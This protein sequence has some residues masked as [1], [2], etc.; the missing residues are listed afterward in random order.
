M[1]I[2]K[3]NAI[4]STNEHLKHL[5][6]QQVVSN[7]TVVW[8]KNQTL[9]KGQMGSS[10]EVEEGKNLTFSVLVKDLIVDVHQLFTLNIVVSLAVFSALEQI[11]IPKLAIKWPNDIL[12]GNSKI[13]GILIENSFKSNGEVYSVVGI[14]LNVNQLSFDNI[15]NASSLAK[16]TGKEYDLE[17][18]LNNILQFLQYYLAQMRTDSPSIWKM[19][20]QKLFKIGVPAPFEKP[21]GE[22]F[23]AII[24][25]V[26]PDGRLELLLENDELVYFDVKE[27]KLLY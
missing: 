8:A 26:I 16:I 27:V 12:S 22:K 15:P 10:W 9:G 17:V 21:N 20:H 25:K 19:Y 23:M 4:S 3:L 6:A 13:G 11:K 1:N 5:M 2:I 7:L 24:Q 18:L 14:G